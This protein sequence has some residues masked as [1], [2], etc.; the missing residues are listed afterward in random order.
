MIRERAPAKLNLFLH[1]LDRRGDGYHEL[2]SLVVFTEFGD[3]LQL[4]S[5]PLGLILEARG[6]FTS[7]MSAL[8]DRDAAFSVQR[9]AERL[10]ETVEWP[11]PGAIIMLDKRIPIAAG[12][13]GGS[14]DAAAT[15]RALS[16]MWCINR[17]TEG[18][19][20]LAIGLGADVPVCL[21]SRPTFVS[22]IGEVLED[23][24]PLPRLALVIAHT[25]VGLP[26]RDVFTALRPSEWRGADAF[27]REPH[28][29]V[30]PDARSLV[31]YLKTTRNDLESP[32]VRLQPQIAALLRDLR[33]AHGCLL[34]RMSGSGAAC[35]GIFEDDVAAAAAATA[36]ER[37]GWW[38]VATRPN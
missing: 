23:A 1:V 25:R 12:L 34:A 36:L 26:T 8:I 30:W 13:G 22:G 16:E 32:A 18:L 9:A 11:P 24:P 37:N 19:G 4:K 21:R 15:L 2:E 20:E 33:E 7:E 6:P 31:E 5:R 29:G 27:L 38:A 3:E 28:A 35:F 10:G 17:S 14:A